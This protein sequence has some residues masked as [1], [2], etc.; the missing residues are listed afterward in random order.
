MRNDSADAVDP[1]FDGPHLDTDKLLLD[2]DAFGTQGDGWDEDAAPTGVIQSKHMPP[3]S[4]DAVDGDWGLDGGA[5][6]SPRDDEDP[7]WD[8]EG[9]TLALSF[10]RLAPWAVESLSDQVTADAKWETAETDKLEPYGAGPLAVFALESR[11]RSKVTESG[12]YRVHAAPTSPVPRPAQRI[13][14]LPSGRSASGVREILRRPEAASS[15]RPIQVDPPP[16]TAARSHPSPRRSAPPPLPPRTRDSR[17]SPE[18]TRASSTRARPTGAARRTDSLSRVQPPPPPPATVTTRNL[19][20]VT[21]TLRPPAAPL[22]RPEPPPARATYTLERAYD[23]QFRGVAGDAAPA[24]RSGGYAAQPMWAAA[25][26]PPPPTRTQLG[27]GPFAPM[28]PPRMS[29]PQPLAA[30]LSELDAAFRPKRAPTWLWL[31][32]IAI[33]VFTLVLAVRMSIAPPASVIGPNAPVAEVPPAETSVAIT[34]RPSG[35]QVFV[36][37]KSTGLI[38]PARVRDLSP[39]L[40]SVDLRMPGYFDTSLAA[41]LEQGK[42]LQLEDIELRPLEAAA[43]PI[44]ATEAPAGVELRDVSSDRAARRAARRER[45][46]A[47]A[48]DVVS[49][50]EPAPVA[51]PAEPVSP[52]SVT[53]G[54]GMLKINS[55]PWARILIDDQ[56]RGNTPQRA[57][58]LPAGTHV[59]HLVNEPMK[60]SKT[61]TVEIRAGETVT[62]IETLEEDAPVVADE[63]ASDEAAL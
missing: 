35:A 2:A 16:P 10:D 20:P 29:S 21:P 18:P 52:E 32:V 39:G 59:V 17:T 38:T 1:Q 25:A 14:S 6:S 33:A 49:A 22:P 5:A 44:A 26:H 31:S 45:R 4:S 27:T 8:D 54:E 43:E 23:A 41:A 55:R 24:T 61:F 3:I 19:R 28:P 46:R 7:H 63:A 11:T 47:L 42:T 37:G 40:H 60:M 30:D 13:P 58:Q 34:T 53:V 57:L 9:E 48:S 62:K 36:D 50:E 15:G 56:F 12:E 51:E